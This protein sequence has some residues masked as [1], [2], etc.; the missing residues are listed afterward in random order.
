MK[1]N[2]IIISL[3]EIRPD[4][5]GCY[6]YSKPI[7]PNID[8]VA[9]EGVR[10]ETCISTADFTPIAMSSVI[11][12]KFPHKSGVRDP[13]SY[14]TNPTLAELMKA[15]GYQTAGFVGNG[16]LA[17]Q[18]G[19]SQGFDFWDQTSEETAWEI[20]QYPGEEV[21]I[22]EGNYWVDKFMNWI[23][24]NHEKPFFIWGHLYETHESSEHALLKNGLIEEGVL[25]DFAYYDAKIKMAD[26]KLI[27][28][29]VDT[30]KKYKI[31]DDTI[32]VIMSDHGTNLGEHEVGRIPWRKGDVFYPQHTTMYD[33]DLKTMMIIKGEKLPADKLITGQ[34]RSVDLLPTVL[35]LCDI[36]CEDADF[37]GVSLLPAV[38]AGKAPGNLAYS[39]DLFEP[40]GRGAI[41]SIRVENEDGKYKYIRNLTDWIEEYFDLDQDPEEKNN[42]MPS[43]DKM[44]A[45]EIR[46]K[47]NKFLLTKAVGGGKDFSKEE[48]SQI[49][50]RLRALGYIE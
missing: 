17:K 41:H 8:A 22:Y 12:G 20:I 34:T 3:D 4:H 31:Y 38:K 48:K 6:G 50:E 15:D 47:I 19:F 43:M 1:K 13:F 35:D 46:K 18:H 28:R 30:L 45:R 33:H 10:F 40:R 9:K 7:S 26:E 14:V 24:E 2:V 49:Q 44:E 21:K 42:L 25:S 27:G 11:T 16:L 29:L 39:E 32:L 36:S 37:D 23:H 5:L